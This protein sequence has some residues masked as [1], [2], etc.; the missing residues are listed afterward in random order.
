[1]QHSTR[2]SELGACNFLFVASN[3]CFL[4]QMFVTTKQVQLNKCSDVNLL[5]KQTQNKKS[6]AALVVFKSSSTF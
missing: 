6:A 2:D 3:A 1:M 4:Q 5:V